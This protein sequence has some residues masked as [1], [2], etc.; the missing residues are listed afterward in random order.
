MKAETRMSGTRCL[1][2]WL[3]AAVLAFGLLLGIAPARAG[4]DD[5]GNPVAPRV[6]VEIGGVAC[7]PKSHP[8]HCRTVTST[9]V[10][11]LTNASSLIPTSP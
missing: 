10:S 6:V 5:D 3:F 4:D 7:S 9:A 2:V 1:P 11:E 8:Q